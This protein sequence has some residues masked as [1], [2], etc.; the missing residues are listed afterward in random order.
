MAEKVMDLKAA[1]IYRVYYGSQ[2]YL[3]ERAVNSK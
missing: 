3:N 2:D 1:I